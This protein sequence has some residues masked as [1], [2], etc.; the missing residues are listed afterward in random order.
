MGSAGMDVRAM[1]EALIEQGYL[2]GKADHV[3]GQQTRRAVRAFQKDQGFGVDGVAGPETLRALM[4]VEGE[5]EAEA[6]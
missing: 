5:A 2:E 1:Q 3:F 6:E 4:G